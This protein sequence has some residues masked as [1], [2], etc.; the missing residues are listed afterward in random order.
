MRFGIPS[1]KRVDGCKT[2]ECLH[3]LGVPRNELVISTQTQDDFDSYKA[4]YGRIATVIN[5]DAHNCA[6]NRNNLLR[7]FDKGERVCLMDDDIRRLA[8]YDLPKDGS[9]YGYFTDLDS[10]LFASAFH[11]LEDAAE[12]TG[13]RLVGCSKHT[14]ATI[15]HRMMKNG[16]R[17]IAG[18]T[19]SGHLL[20]MYAGKETFDESYDCLDDIELALRLI[21]GGKTVLNAA[22]LN[23]IKGEDMHVKGGCMEVYKSGEKE[24]VLSRLIDEYGAI[25]HLRSSKDGTNVGVQIRSGLK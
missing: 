23:V 11:T 7:W 21:S 6:G 15:L 17:W 22:W 24:R 1:Y 25:C 5:C 12:R 13:A 2:A 4:R 14:N 20:V 16:K 18:K 8:R 9:G 3:S 19:I 10:E